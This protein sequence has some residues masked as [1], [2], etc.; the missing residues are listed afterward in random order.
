MK[1]P[2]DGPMPF[3][4]ELLHQLHLQMLRN[5]NS[6]LSETSQ[7]GLCLVQYQS[8]FPTITQCLEVLRNV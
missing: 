8:I 1:F 6:P 5:S 4:Q 7:E 3:L 2:E